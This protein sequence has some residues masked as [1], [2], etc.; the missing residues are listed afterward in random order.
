L[1]HPLIQLSIGRTNG[2]AHHGVLLDNNEPLTACATHSPDLGPIAEHTAHHMCQSC[3][4]AIL[5]LTTPHHPGGEPEGRPAAGAGRGAV[6]HRPIPGHLLGYCGKPLDI[7]RSSGSA[8]IAPGSAPPWNGSSA[9]RV[10]CF[11]RC[12]TLPWQGRPAVG[13]PGPGQHGDGAPP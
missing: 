10:P 11:F 7:R 1:S 8:R 5:A 3:T 2:T 12:R 6:A 13:A 9:E 4:R